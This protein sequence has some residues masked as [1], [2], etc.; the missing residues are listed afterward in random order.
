KVGEF[1]RCS[2]EYVPPYLSLIKSVDNGD[3]AATN[4][5]ADFTLHAEGSGASSS[6]ISGAGNAAA[7]VT[8][9]PVAVGQYELGEIAPDM[10]DTT[11]WLYGYDWTDVQ[12]V[13]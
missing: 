12:C 4:T 11:N 5:A 8:K 13:P 7:Q 2:V 6:A 10:A 9:R 3:T 1:L